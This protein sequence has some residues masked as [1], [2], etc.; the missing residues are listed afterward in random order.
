MYVLLVRDRSKVVLVASVA[1][2][3]PHQL[4]GRIRI[5][6]RIKV[7]SW[8]RIRIEVISWIRI[9]VKCWIPDPKHL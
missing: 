6:I 2:P 8:I 1:D 3:D 4:K 9:V 5:W 7:I